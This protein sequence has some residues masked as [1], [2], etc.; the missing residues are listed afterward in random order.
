M[1]V[2]CQDAVNGL[3]LSTSPDSP[4]AVDWISS[5]WRQHKR[6]VFIL[7]FAGKP[8]YSRYFKMLTK[9]TMLRIFHNA[10]TYC[11]ATGVLLCVT[12]FALL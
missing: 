3:S 8:I 11:V 4:D 12:G 1:C 5:E 6:H 9:L 10:F 2:L 7:S